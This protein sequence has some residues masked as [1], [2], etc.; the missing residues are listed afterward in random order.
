[1]P[2]SPS[3]DLT[4]LRS[5]PAPKY[6]IVCFPYAGGSAYS[7]RS[8]PAAF[9]NE[10][11]IAVVRLPGRYD[12]MGTERF[13]FL[14]AAASAVSDMIRAT[15]YLPTALFGHSLGA[16]LAFEAARTLPKGAIELLV[17]S[18]A[19]A[20]HLL[21]SEDPIASLPDAEFLSRV[22]MLGATPDEVFDNPELIDVIL[23]TLRADFAMAEEYQYQMGPPLHCPILA[24]GGEADSFVD[25]DD[26]RAWKA[27]TTES[28]WSELFPGDHFF[29]DSQREAVLGRIRQTIAH[30]RPVGSAATVLQRAGSGSASVRRIVMTRG[31]PAAGKTTW[32]RAEVARLNDEPV[33]ISLDDL[34]NMFFDG[35]QSA[36]TEAFVVAAR[37]ALTKLA[38]E[39]SRDV[40]IDATNLDPRLE[41]GIRRIVDSHEGTSF[42]I[43]DFTSV[44]L[45]TCIR[46]D[47]LRQSPVG[48]SLIRD[49]Y[50]RYIRDRGRRE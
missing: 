21:R 50:L 43:A 30:M 20:P 7:F 44:P 13:P 25:N 12:R 2:A 17:V 34:R 39:H 49:M 4:V 36:P 1:M 37:D 10:A 35:R 26:L 41:R 11:E 31:L 18:G 33:R 23:P 48:E 15:S 24:L 47:Q 6:R 9:G 5:S 16:T 29:I 8:W 32:A 22:R 42:D 38:L 19:S 27:H 46:R 14:T 45:E 3:V 28:T 40:V